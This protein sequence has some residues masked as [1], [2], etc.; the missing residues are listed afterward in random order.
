MSC[1]ISVLNF[2]LVLMLSIRLLT[3]H[4][5]LNKQTL[6]DYWGAGAMAPKPPWLTQNFDNGAKI[7][8]GS[9]KFSE[10]ID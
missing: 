3:N 10:V 1:F 2:T 6:I 8:L 7:G 4:A 5:A 9:H